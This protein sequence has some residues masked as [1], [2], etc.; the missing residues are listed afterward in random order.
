VKLYQVLWFSSEV[1]SSAV[2]YSEVMSGEVL[3]GSLYNW[4]RFFS[5]AL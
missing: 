4:I 2:L 3:S 1:M 5:G